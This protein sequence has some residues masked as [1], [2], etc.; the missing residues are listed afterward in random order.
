MELKR[1]LSYFDLMNIV[2]GA[3]IGSDIYIVPGLVAGLIGPFALVVW[4]IGGAISM[5]L[6]MVFGYCSYYVPNVGG[7]FAFVSEAFDDF[8]GFIAGWSMSIA[9]IIALPV[10][11][12]VFTNY[13]Q[14]FVPLSYGE[15]LLI[16]IIFIIVLTTVNIVG[17]KAAGRLNDVLTLAKL[18]P[19]LLII[20]LGIGSIVLRPALLGNYTPLA[21]AGLTNFG[22]VLVL[23]FWAYAGFELGVLPASEVVDPKKNIPK[24]MITGMAIVIF[25]YVV[26]NAAVFGVVSS[27]ALAKSPIPLIL[28]ST[29]LLGSAGAVITGVGALASVTGTDE[30][31][32]MGTA[33]LIYAMS[34]D[35]L[36]PKGLGKIHARYQ[37]PYVAVIIE[38]VIA[39]ALMPFSGISALISFAVFNLGVCYL[40]VCLSLSVLKKNDEH[41]LRGQNILPWLGVAI[42][43]Y[44]L[45]STSLLDKVIGSAAILLG[46]P[47]Y[48]HF[49]KRTDVHELRHGLASEETVLSRNLERQNKFLANLVR[50]CAGA[51]RKIRRR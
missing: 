4:I 36:L 7:S 29:A 12:I 42:S 15:Q 40:L 8:F 50:L 27:T 26:T 51:Y 35:G 46:I 19:L 38:G 3:I 28:V 16:R 48:L 1:N 18:A 10:F 6:A 23:I 21:P 49:S 44:L 30:T 13:L 25:F 39:L 43:V 47:I 5:V 9:E 17:V 37:T 32:V 45:Y 20:F 14:Y 31:E 11:A 33:R 41:G 24:A 2:V 22:T 34:S